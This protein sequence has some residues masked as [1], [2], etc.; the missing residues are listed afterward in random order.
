MARTRKR[1]T[2][3]SRHRERVVVVGLGYV[4]LPLAV[5]AAEHGYRVTG[6]EQNRQR[7][8]LLSKGVNTLPQEERIT[9]SVANKI[10]T[11]TSNPAVL[12]QADIIVICVP[13][14]VDHLYIPDLRPVETAART[15]AKYMRRGQL[16]ILESTVNPG[17]CEEVV[18]PILQ[19]QGMKAGR[20]FDLAHCPE[21]I[22]P[23]D[24]N[25]HVGNIP[26]CVGATTTAGA[27]RA[28]A[29]YRSIITGQ[30]R[31]MRSLKEAEA[32]KI[33]ENSFRDINIAF[34]NELARSFD[35]LGIDVYDV[36]Q[37]ASN[38]PFAFMP[39]WP[40]IGVGGHCIPVDPYYLIERA[41]KAG[42]DHKFLSLAREINNG[43]PEYAVRQLQELLNAQK[44]PMAGT[45]IA[46]L[47]LS[48]KANVG[49]IR[50]SPSL[51][52]IDLLKAEQAVVTVYDPYFLKESTVSTLEAALRQ[53]EA[54]I[55]AVNHREFVA[56]DAQT[57]KRNRII[58]VL[59][60]KNC[61]DKTQLTK[62]GIAYKGIGR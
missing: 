56:L 59:D 43:M 54:V 29:F 27:K 55:V 14:P 48:Y 28:A 38:K 1:T 42:F 16:V 52:V 62:A 34:V 31:V 11:P 50:E 8:A 49:D 7:V 57:F 32:T 35:K 44:K 13:T 51:K 61:L 47:G 41:K 22:N 33:I 18:L 46:V 2:K 12:R 24:P 53:A 40:S 6:L 19:K 25:W 3:Q 45:K 30:V 26:R 5:V 58:A 20:D 9:D 21:R 37:G 4:G 15:V 17:V 60:G 23:G 10:F 36:I 39:H